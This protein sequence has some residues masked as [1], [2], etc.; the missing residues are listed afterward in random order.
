M[1]LG[2]DLQLSAGAYCRCRRRHR[3]DVAERREDVERIEPERQEL[4]ERDATEEDQPE[5]R[6]QY[7]RAHRVH[8]RPLREAQFA[9]EGQ[10]GKFEVEH[11]I[12]HFVQPLCFLLLKPQAFY[13]FDIADRFRR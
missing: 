12:I 10:L 4:A 8:D 9:Y 2:H 1:A 7:N 13:E 6:E 3:A 5:H 11:F